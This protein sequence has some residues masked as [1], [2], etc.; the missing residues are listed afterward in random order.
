MNLIRN[1]VKEL[2]NPQEMQTAAATED[3]TIS[4]SRNTT[5]KQRISIRGGFISYKEDPARSIDEFKLKQ[6]EESLRTVM[7]LSCWGPNS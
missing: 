7:Y 1:R 3:S 6:A 2:F 4:K 5:S